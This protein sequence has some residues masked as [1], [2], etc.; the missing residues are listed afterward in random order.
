MEW[1]PHH[2]LG[3]LHRAVG[4][5][6]NPGGARSNV[7]GII[8][9]LILIELTDLPKIRDGGS[10]PP[11]P[12]PWLRQFCNSKCDKR[13]GAMKMVLRLQEIKRGLLSS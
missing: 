12:T 11:P 2:P 5:S 7:V 6:E 8:C 10:A 13:V 3:A 4:R 1:S 9:P